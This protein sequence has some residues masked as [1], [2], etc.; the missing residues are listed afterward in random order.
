[1]VP[2]PYRF[3]HKSKLWY[4]LKIKT[5]SIPCA[6][7]TFLNWFHLYY[8]TN[9]HSMI[10][11][12]KWYRL[13]M[14]SIVLHPN[15]SISRFSTSFIRPFLLWNFSNDFTWLLMAFG[16]FSDLS[17]SLS[18]CSMLWCHFCKCSHLISE[19]ISQLTYIFARAF[20]F[21]SSWVMHR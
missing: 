6:F 12:T 3:G 16:K 1:M 17:L 11:S 14:C 19:T 7:V 15:I 10:I 2:K 4:S 18:V 9:K 5:M 21:C 8:F 13:Y 20:N